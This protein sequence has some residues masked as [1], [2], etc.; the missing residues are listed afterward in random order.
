LRYLYA[1]ALDGGDYFLVIFF[2]FA[3]SFSTCSRRRSR[4]E[5]QKDPR[6]EAARRRRAAPA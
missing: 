1:F 5:P 6:G 3:S 2:F 4:L